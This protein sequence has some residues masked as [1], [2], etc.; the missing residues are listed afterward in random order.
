MK[1]VFATSFDEDLA[2]IVSYSRL[3]YHDDGALV[4]SF[5][6]EIYDEIIDH[7]SNDLIHGTPY[8]I[9]G[10]NYH[11]IPVKDLFRVFFQESGD[12]REVLYIRSMK[13]L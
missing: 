13:I 10:R 4:R 5:L 2:F 1:V 8:P 11:S 6:E 7:L 9:G 3:F 12:T